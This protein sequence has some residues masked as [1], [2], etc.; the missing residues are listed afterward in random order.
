[1]YDGNNLITKI[2]ALSVGG[3]TVKIDG[4]SYIPPKE[5][6]TLSTFS[7][8]AKYCAKKNI[9]IS[10]F[11]FET[12]PDIYEY[13]V[14]IFAIMRKSVEEGLQAEGTLHGGLKLN[15]KA[16]SL[17]SFNSLNETSSM[18]ENRRISSYSLA[19]AEQ[20]ADN[21]T[22][23]TSPTCGASGVL[24][25]VL[26]Y[27]YKDCGAP[28]DKIIRA[29]ATAGIIGN[30]VKTNASISGAECGCQA[31]IGTACSMTAAAMAEVYDL[32]IDQIECAAEIALEHNLGLTCDPVN[33]LVQ[34]PCIERNAMASIK[35]VSAFNLAKYLTEHRKISFD[36]IVKVMYETGKDLRR[37]Y[38]ETAEGGLA[39]LYEKR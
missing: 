28:L 29:L 3:G 22:V 33:G 17:N 23:V 9:R 12:E 32:T 6:Y 25:G 36:D 8:I 31:E 21:K 34:I 1:V 7:E 39:K 15:R 2:R 13:L 27:L 4:E 18:L 19:V 24:P 16:K 20:N 14:N 30:L 5:V 37:P 10:D 35:A 11:V 26:Y 38:R